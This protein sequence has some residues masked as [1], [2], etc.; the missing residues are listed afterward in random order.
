MVV[1][2]L[3]SFLGPQHQLRTLELQFYEDSFNEMPFEEEPDLFSV[4]LLDRPRLELDVFGAYRPR[5][6]CVNKA[7]GV[8]VNASSVSQ[9]C[10]RMYLHVQQF[11]AHTLARASKPVEWDDSNKTPYPTG[12]K[13]CSP[14]IFKICN[15]YSKMKEADLKCKPKSLLRFAKIL[16][17]WYCQFMWDESGYL[18]NLGWAAYEWCDIARK[19]IRWSIE[20]EVQLRNHAKA[21]AA[22]S[23]TTAA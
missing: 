22:S 23:I 17:A 13:Y 21:P 14:D 16:R 1:Y 8:R 7:T 5:P 18:K 15:T 11:I 12:H 10:Q 4:R 6:L 9:A 19:V 20:L 3:F 2:S